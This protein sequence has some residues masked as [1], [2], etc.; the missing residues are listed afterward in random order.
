MK[1]MIFA[2]GLGTRLRPITEFIPKALVPVNGKPMLE[3]N[4]DKLI[5][6]GV[7]EAVVNVHHFSDQVKKFVSSYSNPAITIQISD[8]TDE[9]LDT[10]GGLR[11]ASK[12]LSGAAPFIIH[13]VDILSEIPI[14]KVFNSHISNNAFVTLVVQDRDYD[15]KLIIDEEDFVCG[16]EN[17]VTGERILKR[18]PVG[19]LKSMTFC[20]I[21][22]VNPEIFP[23]INREGAFSIIP[24]YLDL[25]TDYPIKAWNADGY[26]WVD[27]GTPEKLE[28]AERIF[29]D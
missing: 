9:L 16:W 20:S 26:K 7:R 8:E 14:D 18:K 12:F 1:A 28:E 10:G 3:I 11:K 13:N 21:H 25:L 17:L 2:A 4:L 19:D 24:V 5:K 27:I 6:N 15:R 23:L 22:I 29:T